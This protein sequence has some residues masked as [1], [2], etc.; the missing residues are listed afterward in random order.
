MRKATIN[1][2]TNE[3]EIDL[4]FVIEGTGRSEIGTGVAFLDH[5]L[6][7]FTRHGLFDLTI[8]AAGDIELGD[9]HLVEDVGIVLGQAIS[10]ALG[11]HA[12]IARF[13]DV[14]VPMDE[15]SASAILDL[16][17]R[18]YLVFDVGFSSDVVG[19]LTTQMVPHFFHS[20]ITGAGINA[21]IS[22]S[23]ENDHHIIEAIFKA[24]GI[25]LRRSATVERSD[26]PSTKGV[27]T[28]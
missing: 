15:A 28:G 5:I 17:G 26:V 10:Q 7:S 2:K 8:R 21:H 9:H 23:G 3:T 14:R 22:A 27:L 11:D 20:L 1:R 25:A 6:D 18:S 19:D 12:G 13:A 4:T 24:F 16:S